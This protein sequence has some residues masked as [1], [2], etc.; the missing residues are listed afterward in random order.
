VDDSIVLRSVLRTALIGESFAVVSARDASEAIK[1]MDSDVHFDL[2]ITD[3]HMPGLDG[4]ALVERI[5]SHPRYH[6]V[7]ILVLTAGADDLEK[8]RAKEA[9]ATGW[10][11]KPFDT[12]KLAAAI[13]HLIP[14]GSDTVSNDAPEKI[15]GRT[16]S[17][18]GSVL[19]GGSMIRVRYDQSNGLVHTVVEGP[20]DREEVEAY[21]YIL[22]SI[23]AQA[24]AEW[25]RFWHLVDAAS[26]RLQNPETMKGLSG[27]SVETMEPSDRTAIVMTSEAAIQQ[28]KSMPS[29]LASKIFLDAE[30]AK[31]WLLRDG[32]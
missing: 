16:L 25:G 26:L 2:I 18:D 27:S 17:P 30:S 19:Q 11:V 24:R 20:S 15:D 23:M 1:C 31:Q 29:Q 4:A 32:D 7:P 13:N 3:F 14:E 28:L 5:R 22:Y 9:G 8:R 12:A 6:A 10:I 21:L